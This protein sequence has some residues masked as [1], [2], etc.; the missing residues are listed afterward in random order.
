[1]ERI[2]RETAVRTHKPS[3]KVLNETLRAGIELTINAGQV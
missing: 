2:L 1:L 3:E